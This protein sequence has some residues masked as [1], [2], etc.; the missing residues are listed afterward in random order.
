M[1][2]KAQGRAAAIASERR[3]YA[4]MAIAM[5][6]AIVIGFAPS[7]YMRGIVPAAYPLPSITALMHLHGALFTSWMLLFLAQVLLVSGGRPDIHR[8]LGLL[9]VAM[10]P[11]MIVVGTLAGLYQVARASGPPI[12]PPLSWL[13]I[14]L[15]SV[16][17]Y[18]GL[19]GWALV[20]RRDPQTHK[21]LMLIAMIEMTSPGFGRMPWPA[22][23]PGPVILFGF[24]NLFLVALIVWDY[25]RNGGIHR[26]TA[27]GGGIMVASQVFRIA[28]WQTE[29]WLSFARW[30]VSWVA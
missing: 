16:P 7:Y 11:A 20:K 12:V 15:L 10:L 28:T 25:R 21:R 24:S 1:A 8:K 13:S 29:A 23:V 2:T 18:G 26:A 9:A 22:L 14:P 6:A 5:I 3:F 4:G 19:I 27:I 30:A 17:V